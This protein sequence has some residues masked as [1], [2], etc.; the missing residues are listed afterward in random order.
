MTRVSTKGANDAIPWDRASPKQHNQILA[1]DEFCAAKW[2][3][4]FNL[5]SA[6]LQKGQHAAFSTSC[7]PSY[8]SLQFFKRHSQVCIIAPKFMHI[9][10][11]SSPL[12]RMLVQMKG[13]RRKRCATS[14]MQKASRGHGQLIPYLKNTISY[15]QQTK[16]I[17]LPDCLHFPCRFLY[18]WFKGIDVACYIKP[19]NPI[20]A[21]FGP[22]SLIPL[23][24][25]WNL[26]SS[27]TLA[28]A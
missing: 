18:F 13:W 14:T 15:L 17:L 28:V 10:S 6:R 8:D 23:P 2:I 1:N 16:G 24:T 27:S 19:Q 9:N 3:I 22:M 26:L 20:E 12:E 5:N 11:T 25:N 21:W 4:S 7:S